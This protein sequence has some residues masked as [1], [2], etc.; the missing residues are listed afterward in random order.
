L[1]LTWWK[2][3]VKRAC[4]KRKVVFALP[5]TFSRYVNNISTDVCLLFATID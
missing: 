1:K 2:V 3:K 4:E 5:E